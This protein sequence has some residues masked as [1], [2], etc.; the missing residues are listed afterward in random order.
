MEFRNVLRKHSR[1]SLKNL[2]LEYRTKKSIEFSSRS[3][4]SRIIYKNNKTFI[5]LRH[6]NTHILLQTLIRQ[7]KIVL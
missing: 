1:V 7:T 5:F 3:M 4:L 2:F 6:K